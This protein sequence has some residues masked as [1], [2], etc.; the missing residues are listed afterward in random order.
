MCTISERTNSFIALCYWIREPSNS[1][2]ELSNIANTP[3]ICTIMD[4]ESSPIPLQSSLIEL[5]L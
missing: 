4:L 5:A 3:A 1:I 2:K